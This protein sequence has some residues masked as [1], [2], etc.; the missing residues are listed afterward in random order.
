MKRRLKT[1]FYQ[2]EQSP[3]CPNRK[4]MFGARAKNTLYSYYY[5]KDRTAVYLC[6]NGILRQAHLRCRLNAGDRNGMYKK[7]NSEK[8][9]KE[10]TWQVS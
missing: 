10:T 5:V 8:T 7:G 4:N 6:V 9:G 1:A 3:A 2:D